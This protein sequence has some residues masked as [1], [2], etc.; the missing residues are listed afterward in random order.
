MF[1]TQPDFTVPYVEAS[2]PDVGTVGEDVEGLSEF[3]G[4]GYTHLYDA[5]TSQ[6]LDAYA[7]PEALDPRFAFDFGDLSVHE[8]ATDPDTNLAYAAYYAGGMRAFQ[9]SRQGGLVETGKFIDQE[10]SNFWG[11]E[12]FTTAAGE[13]LVAGSDRDFGLVILKYTGPGSENTGVKPA[14]PAA[15]AAPAAPVAP[16]APKVVAPPSS[17]FGFGSLKRVNASG[18]RV[19][20][21][22]TVPGPGRATGTLKA[23]IG[24]TVLALGRASA[25]ARSAGRLRLT[26]RL[27]R[28]A[29]AALRRALAR[30][31][32]R[33][34]SGVLR[35]SFTRTGGVERTRN[36]AV[37]I[38]R[39]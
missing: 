10:G 25:T 14:T 13:R 18:R 3:D 15:P 31:P 34:T 26:F 6:E 20:V 29:D 8:F 1:A 36:R 35:V 22:I 11:V 32:T 2:E 12:Q 37:S 38:A 19:N 4:W 5:K 7:I 9:F 21:T 39:G 24:R 28:T 17:F 33:R 16:V 27:S 23:R 30:R